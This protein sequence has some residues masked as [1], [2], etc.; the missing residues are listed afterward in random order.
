MTGG[1]YLLVVDG[2]FWHDTTNQFLYPNGQFD[3]AYNFADTITPTMLWHSNFTTAPRPNPDIYDPI[4][5]TYSFPFIGGS[6]GGIPGMGIHT[7]SVPSFDY[8][9]V[10][11]CTLYIIDTSVSLYNYSWTSDPLLVPPVI[12]GN[13]VQE[14]KILFAI[15]ECSLSLL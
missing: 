5:H 7:W 8:N 4:N 15:F 6:T 14:L 12:S 10:L 2:V 1:I 13:F 3:A 11:N 9:G